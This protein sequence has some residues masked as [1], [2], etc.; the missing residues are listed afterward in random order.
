MGFSAFTGG[1]VAGAVACCATAGF[2]AAVSAKSATAAAHVAIV[3]S[4]VT[5]LRVRWEMGIILS[6]INRGDRQVNSAIVRTPPGHT[7]REF[8]K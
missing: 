5:R 1:D 3:L 6:S 2:A 8:L 4:G 7:R